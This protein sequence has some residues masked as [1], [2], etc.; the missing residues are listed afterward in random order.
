MRAVVRFGTFL[1]VAFLTGCTAMQ[2]KPYSPAPEGVSIVQNQYGGYSVERV[3]ILKPGASSNPEALQFCFGQNVPGVN[4]A[5]LFNPSKT[6]IT[7]QGKD[8]VTFVVPMTM[9][10]PL[11]YELMFSLTVSSS[12]QKNLFDYTNLKI[13][14]TWSANEAPLPGSSEAAQYVDSARLKLDAISS[15]ISNCLLAEG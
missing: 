3:Q 10:T 12:E 4:G 14:G 15:A 13:R 1:G 9:G 2:I 11:T 6:R 8:Q 7:A 5:A